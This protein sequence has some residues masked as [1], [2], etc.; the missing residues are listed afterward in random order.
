MVVAGSGGE[1]HSAAGPAID[2]CVCSGQGQLQT[3][4]SRGQAGSK[5][6]ESTTRSLT[7]SG[8]LAVGVLSHGCTIFP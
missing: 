6:P 4:S 8:T 3:H 2:A 1:M 5:G 7:A